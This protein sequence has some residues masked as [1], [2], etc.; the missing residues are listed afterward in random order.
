MI[1]DPLL[2]F[3]AALGAFMVGVSKAGITGLSIL[4]I[5]LFN[6]VFP[7]SK[8]ASGLVLP[9]LIF[10]DFVA[11]YSY[12]KHTQWR[13]LWRLFPW[14]AAGVVLGYFTLG[15]ISDH[16][17]RI[18]IGWIIVSLA[19]LSFWRKYSSAGR[20]Q[21]AASF[22]WPVSAAIGMTAGFIT[23][24][25]NAAGP[26]MAIYLVAMRLPKMQY[27]GTA[28][29]FF[30]LLNLFKVPFMVDLGLITPQSFSFNLV[31]A[32][33]VLLGALAGR[34]LLKHVNQNLFEQL[35]LLLSAIG[36]ILLIL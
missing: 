33:A 2:W 34:W 1:T 24:V 8:Q 5:A 27:V 22:R 6:H 21:S 4:S 14:T 11:V 18:L 32:P 30:M 17:A 19:A 26:L 29:V 23:L 3:F 7:S 25:A 28:A 15:R 10:G 35:V 13:Y 9:L 20:E 12:R 31:L 16:A 36:G